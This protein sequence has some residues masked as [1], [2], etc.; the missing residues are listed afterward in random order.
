MQA[1]GHGFNSH[2]F[3]YSPIGEINVKDVN[4]IVRITK[5][6]REK[7]ISMGVPLGEGGITSSL[8]HRHSSWYLCESKNNMRLLNKIRNTKYVK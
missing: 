6:E 4:V 8:T 2:R 5:N 3:H 7:L 1:E